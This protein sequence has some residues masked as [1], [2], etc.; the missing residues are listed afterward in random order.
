MK[1]SCLA[2]TNRPA[3]RPWLLWNYE[4]QTHTDKELVI[5]EGCND[6]VAARNEALAKATGHAVAWFDDDDWHAPD[7]LTLL[8]HRLLWND[9]AVAGSRA[10]LFV[11]LLTGWGC[12]VERTGGVFFNN[13]GVRWFPGLP[14]FTEGPAEDVRWLNI[15]ESTGWSEG[16]ASHAWL[17]HGENV[18]NHRL[19]HEYPM[20]PD[21]VVAFFGGAE[22][23]QDTTERLVELRE[24]L[25]RAA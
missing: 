2:V 19:R 6:L 20:A 1:I 3:F 18:I 7:R 4:K 14:R 13:A 25:A 10:G 9:N 11:D 24:T 17:C 5:V 21:E 12:E 22:A 8:S 15:A 23:W 16:G